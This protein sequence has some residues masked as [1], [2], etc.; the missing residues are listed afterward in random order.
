MQL[1]PATDVG[2]Y[3][4]IGPLGSGGMGVVYGAEDQRLGR[5]VAIK[6]LT[7]SVAY[8]PRAAERFQREARA[9][10]SLNHPNICTVYDVGE[11]DGAPFLVMELLEGET[12]G[13]RL[14]SATMPVA[15]AVA[16]VASIA[17][18]LDAAHRRGIVHGDIKPANIFLTSRGEAKLVDFGLAR[19][20]D[21]VAATHDINTHTGTTLGTIAYMSPEQARSD[22]IDARSDLFSLGAS[23]YEL[24]TG[25]VPFPG[26]S[27]AVMFDGI[28]NKHPVAPSAL[29]PRIPAELDRIILRALEKDRELRYQSAADFKADLK[30]VARDTTAPQVPPRPAT[31]TRRPV[32]L[33]AAIAVAVIAVAAFVL[34]RQRPAKTG[35]APLSVEQVT[36]SGDVTMAALSPDGKYTAYAEAM[37]EG[38]ALNVRQL[39]TKSTVTAVPAGKYRYAGIAFSTDSAYLYL[40]TRGPSALL[41]VAVFGGVVEKIADEIVTA[42]S[43]SPDGRELAYIRGKLT[44]PQLIV[45]NADGTNARVVFTATGLCDCPPG[46]PAWSPDGQTIAWPGGS[47]MV[48]GMRLV[49][50]DGKHSEEI[51]LPGWRYI[52]SVLW[53]PSNR[54]FLLTAEQTG[55][56]MTGRHQVIEVG[57]PDLRVRRV[58]NDLADYHFLTGDPTKMV[59]AV[60]LFRRAG[61]W[62]AP[63]DTPDQ[64]RHVGSGGSD[65]SRGLAWSA[66]G[67]LVY[68][69]SYS[70]GWIA[71]ANGTDVRPLR[72]DRQS[73]LRPFPCGPDAIGYLAPIGG[74][75]TSM[76]LLDSGSDTPRRV[77][78]IPLSLTT[79]TADGSTI[80]FTD[81]E[82]I[83]K[84]AARGG[85]ASVVVPNAHAPSL[86]PDGLLLAAHR[87]V[88]GTERL[89][90]FSMRDGS[91]LRTLAAPASETFQWDPNGTSLIT[92]RGEGNVDN[93][94]RVP[95]DGSPSTQ[96]THFDADHIFFFGVSHDGRLAISRG[97]TA[98]DIVL[99]KW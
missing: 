61:I 47:P 37:P 12:L 1:A 64:V 57:Y 66:D 65:G 54:G 89:V 10:S 22:A 55:R 29:N 70:V 78:D 72:A 25:A 27:A 41:R 43:V 45:A 50:R 98:N 93:L 21:P 79:C 82:T 7:A 49:A 16:V 60:Q 14:R 44:E 32:L 46:R 34:W 69:D 28:L 76:F 17:D 75:T 85:E 77:I 24:V 6:F 48:D 84:V 8:D 94:W 91:L 18:A 59:T 9:A 15:E 58:T 38:V 4:I 73:A 97:E 26:A 53:L 86:S 62:V 19:M 81:G 42:V 36:E 74:T 88:D 96:L 40:T 71:N 99:M 30:R 39:Q 68:V 2:P 31:A 80:L 90:L 35:D 13:T 67:R 33:A 5:N 92:A 63:L 11:Y 3:R 95:I 23:L 52:E 87:T 20:S 83:K 51:H 56:E